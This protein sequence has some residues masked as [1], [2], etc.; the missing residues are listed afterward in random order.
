METEKS[1][2]KNARPEISLE[3]LTEYYMKNRYHDFD[4]KTDI[5][6]NTIDEHMER[7]LEMRKY[8]TYAFLTTSNP[9]GEILFPEENLRRYRQFQSDMSGY[10]THGGEVRGDDDNCPASPGLFILGISK[11]KVL[12]FAVKYGQAAFLFG[13]KGSPA[14]LVF[15]PLS[16]FAREQVLCD[17]F[18]KRVGTSPEYARH[19]KEMFDGPVIIIPDPGSGLQQRK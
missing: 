1:N 9:I 18:N 4:M 2:S 12:E 13:E 15:C 10:E 17:N 8:N 7:R 3:R 11:E 14:S 16:P 6:I 19:L 5:R